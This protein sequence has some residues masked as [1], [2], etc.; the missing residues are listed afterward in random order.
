MVAFGQVESAWPLFNVILHGGRV[1]GRWWM[2]Y[3]DGED[4][5]AKRLVKRPTGFY[6]ETG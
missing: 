4:A 2:R 3:E 6:V 5:N 1:Y